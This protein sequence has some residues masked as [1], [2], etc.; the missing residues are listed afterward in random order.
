MYR[1][2]H[3]LLEKWMR[4][5]DPDTAS[6][7]AFAAFL[8]ALERKKGPKTNAM[9]A[10][11]DFEDEV[12][13]FIENGILKA[14]DGPGEQTFVAMGD[15]HV[16]EKR[17]FNDPQS[18]AI[19]QIGK[20][21]SGAQL[22]VREE[23]TIRLCG[24]DIHLVGVADALKAGMLYDI[25]RVQRYEYGKY[26]FSTQHPMYFELF[27]EAMKF[28]YL[29]FDGQYLYREDYRRGDFEPIETTAAAFLR[30]LEGAGLMD[31][32]KE[33]WREY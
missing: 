29:I 9:Q 21:L 31:I 33:H 14:E 1:L 15:T 22:Q 25:K 24:M 11:I 28:S 17:K 30:Y 5:T 8:N 4:C 32:Y 16:T 18:R 12:N 26:Q 2:T 13:Y 23:K 19:R 10:G 7:E 6:D 20:I 3:S 27:P